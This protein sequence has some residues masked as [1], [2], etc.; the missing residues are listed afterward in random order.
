M[1]RLVKSLDAASE[2]MGPPL[3]LLP[4]TTFRG[5]TVGIDIPL[6]TG[7]SIKQWNDGPAELRMIIPTTQTRDKKVGEEEEKAKNKAPHNY[8]PLFKP[9]TA[10]QILEEASPA[11]P[12]LWEPFIPEGALTLLIAHPKAGK[13]TFMTPLAISLSRGED[14]LERPVKQTPVFW[15]GVEEKPGDTKRRFQEFGLRETDTL[16]LLPGML[17]R[18]DYFKDLDAY[19]GEKKFGLVVVDTLSTFWSGTKENDVEAVTPILTE[20][21]QLARRHNVTIVLVYHS[22]KGATDDFVNAVRGSSA[23]AGIV[24]QILSF[25]HPTNA[26]KTV[27]SLQSTGRYGQY[28][29]RMELQGTVLDVNYM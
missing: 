10:K 19:L 22:R 11:I 4:E 29:V 27:R 25:E 15:H 16:E 9:L 5:K 1:L 14:F 7:S 21:L 23:I 13:S 3:D 17:A 2:A 18:K 6:P 12:W 24:D 26:G 20:F 8:S 28:T